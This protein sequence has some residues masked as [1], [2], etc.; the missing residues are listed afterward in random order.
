M[1]MTFA[2]DAIT[3]APYGRE[4]AAA[5]PGCE[6]IELERCGHGAMVEKPDEVNEALIGFF[7]NH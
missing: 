6:L 1:V 7:K 2:Q 5:I 3:L 4:V